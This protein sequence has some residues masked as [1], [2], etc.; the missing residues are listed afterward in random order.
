MKDFK[1]KI[2][3]V[4]GLIAVIAGSILTLP[5]MGIVLPVAVVAISTISLSISGGIVAYLT[6]KTADG[7]DKNL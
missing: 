1:N 4:C 2:S 7:K 5:T 6:G 3:N